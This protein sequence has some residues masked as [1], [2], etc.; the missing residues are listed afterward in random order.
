[1]FV[2]SIFVDLSLYDRNYITYFMYNIIISV[3]QECVNILKAFESVF[4]Y[5]NVPN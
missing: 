5:V 4:N 2:C 1:M 3:K